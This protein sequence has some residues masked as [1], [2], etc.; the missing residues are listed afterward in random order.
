[1]DEEDEGL[2]SVKFPDNI[3]ET[4]F[5]FDMDQSEIMSIF[6]LGLLGGA[7]WLIISEVP[8]VF[9]WVG[10]AGGVVLGVVIVLQSPPGQAPL[11]W[12]SA[13]LRLSL[14][15]PQYVLRAPDRSSQTV[16]QEK[17]P[18]KQLREEI[19]DLRRERELSYQ[20]RD[21]LPFTEPDENNADS[22]ID[23]S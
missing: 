13:R 18:G 22:D 3:L 4:T 17:V 19:A 21:A 12:A 15:S 20:V 16:Y 10:L 23:E 5:F 2:P 1:M 11:D 7:P 14:M 9:A 8:E 6:V